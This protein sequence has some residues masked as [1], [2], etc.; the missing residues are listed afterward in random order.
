[1]P[2]LPVVRINLLHG[3]GTMSRKA[4]LKGRWLAGTDGSVDACIGSA[5]ADGFAT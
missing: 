2:A 1:M 5:A 4:P 3:L